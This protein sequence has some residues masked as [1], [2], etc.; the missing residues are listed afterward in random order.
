MYWHSSVLLGAAILAGE[1]LL[2]SN[3]RFLSFRLYLKGVLQFTPSTSLE[4]AVPAAL[5][6]PNISEASLV[7]VLL[8]VRWMIRMHFSFPVQGF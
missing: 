5:A 3:G 4:V 1:S 7:L 2:C 6:V 8:P